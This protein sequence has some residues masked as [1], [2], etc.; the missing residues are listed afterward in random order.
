M[1]KF[2]FSVL[3]LLFCISFVNVASSNEISF[4]KI[5][6][7]DLI[8]YTCYESDLPH[9]DKKACYYDLLDCINFDLSQRTDFFHSKEKQIFDSFI[10][11][12]INI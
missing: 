10:R 6:L 8:H 1:L 4:E 9:I 5:M 2:L 7:K 12:T 11:C 3:V